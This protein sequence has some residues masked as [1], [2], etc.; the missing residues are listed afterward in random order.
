MA[1]T[2]GN[3]RAQAPGGNPL[4]IT[5]LDHVVLRVVDLDRMLAFYR[6]V[7]GGTVERVNAAVGLTQLRVGR[8]LLDL[9]PVEGPIGRD[10]GEAPGVEGH[11]MDHFCFRVECWDEPALRAWLEAHGVEPGEVRERYG[12]DGFGPSIYLRD[13]QGNRVELKGPPTRGLSD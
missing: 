4:R 8:A 10:G 13:P 12:E 1:G 3:G 2:E 7:L 6:D 11:N 9:V 5:H